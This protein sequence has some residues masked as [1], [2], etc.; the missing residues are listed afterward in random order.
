MWVLGG[1]SASVNTRSS[2]DIE[3]ARVVAEVDPAGRSWSE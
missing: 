3:Q 2:S 1:K